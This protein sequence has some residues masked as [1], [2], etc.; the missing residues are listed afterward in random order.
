MRS[1]RRGSGV[2]PAG[3]VPLAPPDLVLRAL[4]RVHAKGV[5]L[6]ERACFRLLSA[7]YTHPPF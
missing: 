6:C 2:G 3:R 5:V 7:F 1:G 4:N